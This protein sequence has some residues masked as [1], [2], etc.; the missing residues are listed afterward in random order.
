M[1]EHEWTIAQAR[2]KLDS[3]EITAVALTEAMLERVADVEN[4]V[5]AFL[6]LSLIHI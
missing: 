6:A 5:R 2:A 3:G 4:S 1:N